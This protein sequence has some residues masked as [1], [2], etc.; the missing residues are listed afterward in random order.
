M[1]ISRRTRLKGL[2]LF[3]GIGGIA[4]ALE[5]W[6]ET[7]AYCDNDPAAQTILT[8]R[9]GR[10][11]IEVAPIWDD[12]TTLTA[13]Q[14]PAIDLVAGGFPC[15]DISVSGA[16]RGLAGQRSGLFF[17]VARLV[18]ELRPKFVFLENVSAISK[19]GGP[20][21]IATLAEMGYRVRWGDLS[22]KAVGATH[23]RARW[24]CLA[25]SNEAYVERR[26]SRSGLSPQYISDG[27]SLHQV[28][29]RPPGPDSDQWEQLL[30]AEPRMQPAIYRTDVGVSNWKHRNGALGN[31]VDAP[32]AQAAFKKLIG[33]ES[34]V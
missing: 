32:T 24:W 14:L 30:Q 33:L 1:D 26:G 3:S 15:Q 8:S 17:E 4:Q 29:R 18:R 22:A 23:T 2:D 7:V 20:Q 11:E 16:G 25:Y 5:P 28:D 34:T 27:Q 6:V 13:D 31:S 12:V 19:R 21:V 9:M 10:G